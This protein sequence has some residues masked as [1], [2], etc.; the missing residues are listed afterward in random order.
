[1]AR[2]RLT[3]S[4]EL[5]I[6]PSPA[7]TARKIANIFEPRSQLGRIDTVLESEFLDRSSITKIILKIYVTVTFLRCK[8]INFQITKQSFI[9]GTQ[10]PTMTDTRA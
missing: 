3:H 4:P 2:S 5:V 8:V 9:V 10:T 6:N 7:I 1:M